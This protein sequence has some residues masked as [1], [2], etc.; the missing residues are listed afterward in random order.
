MRNAYSVVNV[1]ECRDN[2]LLNDI[3]IFIVAAQNMQTNFG[4][5]N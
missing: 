1:V 5:K 2:H 4:L 3:Y